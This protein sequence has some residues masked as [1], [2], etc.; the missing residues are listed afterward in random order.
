MKKLLLIIS[1]MLLTV[2]L[3]GCELLDKN[4][5][6][7]DYENI[8]CRKH[9]D[10]N[11]DDVCDECAKTLVYTSSKVIDTKTNYTFF[12]TERSNLH[13]A[14]L[15]EAYEKY[16]LEK[17]VVLEAWGDYEIYSFITEADSQKY[18]LDLFEVCYEQGSFY[19]I[20]HLNDIY[21]IA[22]FDLGGIDGPSHCLTHV[23]V[24]D[25]N[26]DGY[27]EVMTAINSFED[28]GRYYYCT[29]FIQVTDTY[30]KYSIDINDYQNITYFKENKDGVICIYNADGKVPLVS[31]LNNGK[32]DEKYYDLANNLYDTPVLNTS[33]YEFEEKNVRA[34]CDL[35]SVDIT[36]SD[37]SIM[38]P[39]LFKNTYTP[40][41]FTIN[42]K[43]TYLGETFSYVNGD[44]YLDGATVSFVDEKRVISCEGWVAFEVIT[45]FV[46]TKG[47]VIEHTYRYLEDLNDVN[48]VGEYD[49]IINYRN[50]HNNINETIVI[51]DFLKVSR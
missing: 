43:M 27:I 5:K 41:Y 51:E 14:E 49:M 11:E 6:D 13:N 39:Y 22:P 35:Y 29:S 25:I 3:I 21:P 9:V 34:A 23:A 42:V 7:K 26:A 2:S 12:P 18:N 38:F 30:T 20:K 48:N 4:P 15:I 40:P 45:S 28:R 31:D 10:E 36:I 24:T 1:M 19:Y 17:N 32:L 16:K 50:E 8:I 44:S 33:K 47:M 37:E 46:I